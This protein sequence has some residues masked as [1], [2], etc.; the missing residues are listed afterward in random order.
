ML[1]LL[2]VLLPTPLP[3][4][5]IVL[6]LLVV[7]ERKLPS[8]MAPLLSPPPPP[9]P[10]P[11]PK[12]L[13]VAVLPSASNSRRIFF[14]LTGLTLLVVDVTPGAAVGDGAGL[15]SG[16]PTSIAP[17]LVNQSFVTHA[18]RPG[19]VDISPNSWSVES[20]TNVLSSSGPPPA[21]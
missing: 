15:F 19:L 20:S 2:L 7:V 1:T 14:G 12:P 17:W 8:R 6:P 11:P 16:R 10:P 5:A 4:L 3:L 9:P 21:R 13:L 18:S